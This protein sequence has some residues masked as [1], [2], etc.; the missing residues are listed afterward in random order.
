MIIKSKDNKKSLIGSI[1]S[2]WCFLLVLMVVFLV[3]FMSSK[4]IAAVAVI[5]V[6]LLLEISSKKTEID[7]ADDRLV[8]KKG[9][10]V[11]E[12]CRQDFVSCSICGNSI[13]GRGLKLRGKFL[14]TV[15]H[16]S[17]SQR[18]TFL[19]ED[20]YSISLM[21]LMEVLNRWGLSRNEV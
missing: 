9:V 20:R 2:S 6:V 12:L 21:E 18:D 3:S 10:V 14:V 5:I 4:G 11:A 16:F 8:I 7:I 17:K 1:S 13:F 15:G 19:I